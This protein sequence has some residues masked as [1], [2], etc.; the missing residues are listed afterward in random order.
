MLRHYSVRTRLIASF[1][2][3][4]ALALAI[5]ALAH[6]RISALQAA[7]HFAIQDVARQVTASDALLDAVNDG[8]RGKLTIFAVDPGAVAD[9]AS[10]QVAVARKRIDAAYAMLD[11]LQADSST[12]DAGVQSRLIAIKALRKIHASAFDNA[13]ELQNNGKRKDAQQLLG[14]TVLP[15]LS[16]YVSEIAA[17]NSYQQQRATSAA[18]AAERAA[19][20]GLVVI[21]ALVIVAVTCGSFMAY[22]VWRS[23]SDPLAELTIAA[24]R[25]SR[26][27]VNVEWKQTTAHD[28]VATLAR[29]I[30][31]IS[32]AQ[33]ALAEAT[34]RLANGDT[35]AE[36]PVRGAGDV[37]GLAA[38]QVRDTLAHLME[39]IGALAEA[40][41]SGRLN[42]RAPAEKFQGTFR[43]LIVGLNE[44]LD[45][46]LSPTTT[47]RA[48]LERFAARD[49][50]ARM[51]THY[52]GDHAALAN[53][54]NAAGVALDSAIHE[55]QQSAQQVSTASEQIAQSST[56]LASGAS[57]QATAL[58]EVAISLQEMVIVARQNAAS[59]RTAAELVTEVRS[60]TAA[61]I[62]QYHSPG[63]R[64]VG[65]PVRE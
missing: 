53:A 43:A 46:V 42:Q 12:S 65:H 38:L 34:R 64:D 31:E 36:V 3:L 44:T 40:A 49:L 35:A 24:N 61:R 39:E 60:C 55:V 11:S 10:R 45:A 5:G 18:E 59:A 16:R 14:E 27:D 28:E 50:S 52:S 7:T 23:V 25:L 4:L 51:P 15:S 6:N 58:E 21:A 48:V 47:A 13:A 19:D 22:H 32:V 37:V 9:A 8:A 30:E 20:Y 56:S 17:L 29:A 1:G 41:S 57:E 54:I 26:G 63:R 2:A 62:G 33:R